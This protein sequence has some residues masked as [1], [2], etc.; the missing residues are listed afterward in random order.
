MI[1]YIVCAKPVIRGR[2]G[3]RKG[4]MGGRGREG[5]SRAKPGNQ[6]VVYNY[7]IILG[8]NVQDSVPNTHIC[9]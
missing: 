8:F 7:G 6:L 5:G 4:R 1:L 9:R 2:E 3:R